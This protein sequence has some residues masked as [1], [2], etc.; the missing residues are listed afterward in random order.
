VNGALR[1]PFRVTRRLAL[2]LGSSGSAVVAH[3]WNLRLTGRTR[4]SQA[5]A[6]WLHVWSRRTL[7]VLGIRY[8]HTGEVPDHGLVVCNHL[9]YLDILVLAAAAPMV[10]VSK[11]DVERWP[12]LGTLARCGGTLFLKRDRR[13]HVA[14]IASAFRPI[15]EGGTVLTLFPEGTSSGGESVLPFRSSLLEPA[16]ANGWPVTPASITYEVAGGTVAEDVAYW[17][18]MVF[19][20]HFLNLLAFPRITG[21]VRF[22]RA[23]TGIR[24]RKVLTRQLHEAV[25]ELK[26]QEPLPFPPTREKAKA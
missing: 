17:R 3:G 22:G 13:G 7:G 15:V 16:A 24:D 18:E 2:F 19:A 23:V 1:H 11:A 6:Q 10:F 14:E 8:Q 26:C 5:C 4:D 25:C 21:T 20:P 12:Y 9:G